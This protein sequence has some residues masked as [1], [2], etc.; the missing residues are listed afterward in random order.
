MMSGRSSAESALALASAEALTQHGP[1]VEQKK[2]PRCGRN[3]STHPLVDQLHGVR[4]LLR[5]NMSVPFMF[6]VPEFPC[7]TGRGA[8]N[9]IYIYIYI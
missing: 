5:L 7:H 4:M 9:H 3:G 6:D 2:G 1:N 8:M